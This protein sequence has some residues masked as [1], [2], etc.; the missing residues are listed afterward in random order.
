MENRKKFLSRLKQHFGDCSRQTFLQKLRNFFDG[1]STNLAEGND[2]KES[3]EHDISEIHVNLIDINST[4]AWREHVNRLKD[5]TVLSDCLSRSKMLLK[6]TN[7]APFAKSVTNSI[8]EI[9]AYVDRHFKE[10]MDITDDTS[11]DVAQQTGKLVKVYVRDLLRGCHSGI[12]HSQ[13]TERNF[14]ESF[15]DCLEGYLSGIGV[16]RKNITVGMDVRVNAKWFD[17]PFIRE[18]SDV[19]LMGN[20][21]EIEVAPY[22]IPY[23]DDDGGQDELILKGVCIAFGESKNK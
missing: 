11:E 15:Y 13:G 19:N 23:R 18:T 2:A 6:R 12:K 17:T 3:S 4:D 7:M 21:D 20:I 9:P 16:Y 5:I 10:P 8:T 22:F 14:F 1:K